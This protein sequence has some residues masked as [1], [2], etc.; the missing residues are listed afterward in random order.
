MVTTI[1]LSEQE[2]S[3][4]KALTKQTDPEAA[5]RAAMQDYLRYARRLQLKQLSGQVQMQDNWQEM[6]NAELEANHDADR[7]GGH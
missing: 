2:L 5:V 4:L 7:S 1:Q 6:E 3:D